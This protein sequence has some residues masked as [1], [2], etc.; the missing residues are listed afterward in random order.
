[1][2]GDPIPPD[3][4]LALHCQPAHLLEVDEAGEP[5]GVSPDVFRVDD[6]GISTNWI[7]YR[8]AEPVVQFAEACLLLMSARTIREKHRVGILV[9]RDVHA[10]GEGAGKSV[11]VIHD[12]I[13]LPSLNPAHAL[14]IGIASTDKVLLQELATVVELRRFTDEAL[15]K[16][17]SAERTRRRT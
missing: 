4:H 10:A 8:A 9:V 1:L 11:R 12:P 5:K 3:D 6:D 2:K 15:Q 17:K 7:E 16:S 13:D 14:I